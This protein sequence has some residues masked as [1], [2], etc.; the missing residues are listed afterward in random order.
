MSHK[1]LPQVDHEAGMHKNKGLGKRVPFLPDSDVDGGVV[2][3]VNGLGTDLLLGTGLC[4]TGGLLLAAAAPGLASGVF[5]PARA[6]PA[7]LVGEPP[8]PPSLFCVFSSTPLS[9]SPSGTKP[10]EM[11]YIR[12]L[13]KM[14]LSPT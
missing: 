4:P 13:L 6:L 8:P 7:A 9:W 11:F 5:L 3:E 1:L 14:V 12:S 2:Q 10:T